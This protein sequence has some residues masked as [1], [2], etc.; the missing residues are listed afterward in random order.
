MAR[1]STPV[2]YAVGNFPLGLIVADFDG[3]GKLDLAT[4]NEF[5]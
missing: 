1:F 3:D 4:A 2:R 5:L